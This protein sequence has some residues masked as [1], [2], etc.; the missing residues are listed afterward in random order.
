MQE[1]NKVLTLCPTC[2]KDINLVNSTV[3]CPKVK[4]AIVCMSHCFTLC[5]YMDDAISLTRCTYHDQ[6]YVLERRTRA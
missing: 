5:R 6:K 3:H 4:G 2:L 1:N